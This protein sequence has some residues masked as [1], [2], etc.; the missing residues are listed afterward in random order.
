MI[1]MTKYFLPIIIL[2]LGLAPSVY[3]E[4]PPLIRAAHIGDIS[5]VKS[6]LAAGVDINQR[7]CEGRTALH[8]TLCDGERSDCID[9]DCKGPR[10][11]WKN[12]PQQISL[13]HETHMEDVEISY[14]IV[15]V[16]LQYGIDVN[17]KDSQGNIALFEVLRYKR[18]GELKR[19]LTLF[20][21]YGF[22]I[23]MQNNV[24]S[25]ILHYAASFYDSELVHFLLRKGANPN[26][27]DKKGYRPIDLLEMDLLRCGIAIWSDTSEY[28]VEKCKTIFLL[29]YYSGEWYKSK[30][31]IKQLRRCAFELSQQFKFFLQGRVFFT[32]YTKM[33]GDDFY[34]YNI[35]GLVEY[36]GDSPS[37][38]RQSM[39][40]EGKS[41][42][43]IRK[44]APRSWDKT[45]Q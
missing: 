24:G 11:Y 20:L 12:I 34:Y 9:F 30:E 23:N 41:D 38:S 25:T 10:K 6:L 5:Q 22:D 39:R 14:E 29:Q 33:K 16:L 7:D 1:L 31:S 45:K 35:Y 42:Y 27:T 44:Y 43:I 36:F 15:K 17:A 26:L 18:R 3:M 40:I 4:V 28:C 13:E 8:A 19:L 21:E 37:E 32:P 2:F